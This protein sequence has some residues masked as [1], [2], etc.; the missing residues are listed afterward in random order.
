MAVIALAYPA[1][2]LT[3]QVQVDW[4]GAAL[5]F[6]GISTLLI[7]IGGDAGSP[8]LW[9]A[10]TIV[11]LGGFVVAQRRAAEPILPLSLVRLP[12][13]SRT[14]VVVFLVGIAMFGAI[15]FIPLFVQTVQGGTAT[16]AGQVLT[17]LFLGWV[18]MSIVGAR[19][20]V[21]IGYR[22]SAIGGSILMTAGFLG[23]STLD[24]HSP[25]MTLLVSCTILGAGM[26]AQMLS[27]LLAV[28]HAV[29]RSQLGLAT[30]LNQFSRS[31][32][33]ALGVSAMGAILA[34]G[35][36]GLAL[37]GG[38]ESALASGA[39]ALSGPMR[40]QFAAALHRVFI[41]GAVVSGAGLLATMF[42]P[43][44]S[45][46]HGVPTGAGEQMLEAEMTNLQPEDEPIAINE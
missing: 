10:A 26:G 9:V 45:F 5:L 14:I 21:R 7:A 46:T 8:L 15:A 19:I 27:L 2:R 34:R 1:S 35:L 12:V 25:R 28:Q 16:Q 13:I 6:S 41:A 37:P 24:S 40:D 32:G 29:D 30:S 23:L 36:T 43:P 22:V 39:I 31:V 38:A 33:A 44:V 11:L 3:R 4:L 42:L 18:V 17:P 20:T